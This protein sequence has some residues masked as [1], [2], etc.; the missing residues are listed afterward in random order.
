M[1]KQD[2][3]KRLQDEVD[4][5]NSANNGFTKKVVVR[6]WEN[7]GKSRTYYSIVETRANSKHFKKKDYG[8]WDNQTNTFSDENA[9]RFTFS[10]AN[11]ENWEAPV[12]KKI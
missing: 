10:G 11:Y 5:A 6:D 12:N 1:T 8:Y 7:Y 4:V 2:V 3:E 9:L